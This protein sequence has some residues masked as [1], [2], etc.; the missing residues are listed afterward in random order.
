MPGAAGG[1]WLWQLAARWSRYGHAAQAAICPLLLA[2]VHGV[3]ETGTLFARVVPLSCACAWCLCLCW[4]GRLLGFGSS[5][6]SSTKIN[7]TSLYT[8]NPHP[9]THDPR[10]TRLYLPPSRL[11]RPPPF[12]THPHQN[13]LR[14][15]VCS[16][17]SPCGRSPSPGLPPCARPHRHSPIPP[18][19]ALTS[20]PPSPC[21]ITAPRH[22]LR[23]PSRPFVATQPLR[24][25]LAWLWSVL[26]ARICDMSVT[27][28]RRL[29]STA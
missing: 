18:P 6:C 28:S 24:P 14:S 27:T 25:P 21:T 5:R 7:I 2:W 22:S 16:A 26:S 11:P 29:P 3:D 13:A 15:L 4:F 9:T 20:S 1:G 19:R 23:Q 12:S 8:H 17:F 10:S